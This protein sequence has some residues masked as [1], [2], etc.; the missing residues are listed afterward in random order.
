MIMTYE[1]V[2]NIWGKRY[3]EVSGRTLKK[4]GALA[5]RL[6]E[7]TPEY[8]DSSCV[9]VQEHNSTFTGE[10]NNLKIVTSTS[11]GRGGDYR[12]ARYWYSYFF[13]IVG[14]K[15]EE[16]SLEITEKI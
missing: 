7:K 14:K 12:R 15:P 16:N 1:Q 5:L 3:K 10:K 4:G 9:D 6:Q 8:V 13:I 11:S 2:M